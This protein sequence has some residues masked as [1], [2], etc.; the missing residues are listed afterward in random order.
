MDGT[1]KALPLYDT[2]RHRKQPRLAQ[3]YAE[4]RVALSP[5]NLLAELLSQQWL[6]QRLA[7]SFIARSITLP[8]VPLLATRSELCLWA[9]Q[10]R[11]YRS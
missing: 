5:S 9:D 6:F 2:A 10:H 11:E 3:G 4:C 1:E 8:V 7:Q